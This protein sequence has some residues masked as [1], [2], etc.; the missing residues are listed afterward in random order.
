R[1]LPP[2]G[3]ER[4]VPHPAGASELFHAI[5]AGEGD[6]KVRPAAAEAAHRQRRKPARPAG[7]SA[8]AQWDPAPT[9]RP[10][11]RHHAARVRDAAAAMIDAINSIDSAGSTGL[12]HAGSP[13]IASRA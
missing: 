9:E 1:H 4:S 6:A 7:A 10:A 13:R 5:V 11:V 2:A 3:G 12:A 8:A